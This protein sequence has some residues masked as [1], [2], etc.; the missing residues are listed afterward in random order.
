MPLRVNSISKRYSQQFGEVE[1][2]RDVSFSLRDGEFVC[3]VGPSGCGKSTLLSVIAGLEKA[4]SGTTTSSGKVGYIFQDPTLFP[5]LDVWD[6]VAFSLKMNGASHRFIRQQVQ[7]YLDLV[8]LTGFAHAYPHQ[9]SGGMKQRVALIR[10]LIR[11]PNTLLLD[12]PFGS[13]DAM[14]RE[15]LYLDIQKIWKVTK[16]TILFVTHNVREAVCLGDRVLVM[17]SRPGHITKE[18]HISLKRPRDIGDLHVIA[19]SH[20]VRKALGTNAYEQA[21][22]K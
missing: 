8:R 13:V 1:A 21:D 22:T 20:K 10:A 19:C 4:S 2:L 12:E 17:S 5:W 9:L 16:T 6:N 15:N 14:T 3:L 18:I 7:E 11:K